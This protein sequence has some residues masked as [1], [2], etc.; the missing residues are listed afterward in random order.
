M[1]PLM[2]LDAVSRKETR[3]FACCVGW[4]DSEEA[5]ALGG[6]SLRQIVLR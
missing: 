2:V 3:L 5:M 4:L 6:T 1:S